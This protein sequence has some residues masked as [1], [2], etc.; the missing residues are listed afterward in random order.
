[1]LDDRISAYT[2]DAPV[3]YKSLNI[4]PVKVIDYFEFYSCVS[5]L[6][7]DKNS[8]P[9]PKII[10]MSYFDFLIYNYE[11]SINNGNIFS[12]IH[13]FDFLLRICLCLDRDNSSIQ[14]GKYKNKNVFQIEGEIFYSNDFDEIKKIILEQ[15]DV[16]IPDYNIKKEV[17]EELELGKKLKG[18]GTKLCDFEEQKICLSISTGLPLESID[19]LTIRKYKKYLR[20]S[21]EKIHY[22]IYKTAAMSGFVEFKDKDFPKHWMRD[23]NEENKYGDMLIPLEDVEKKFN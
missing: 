4:Y 11:K 20:R 22:E 15:N 17:R 6:L 1:M 16:E 19:N 9:D 18:A 13:E 7:I 8:I 10:S 2:Y 5:C 23:L 14:Y 3:K 12:P 21:D